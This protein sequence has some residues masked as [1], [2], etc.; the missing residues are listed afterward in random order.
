MSVPHRI[1]NET[2]GRQRLKAVCVITDGH[3]Y[4]LSIGTDPKGPRAYL[5]P[6][7]GGIEFGERASRAA[8]RE[9]KEEIG[10]DIPNPRLLGILENI[11][12]WNGQPGHEVV[13]C[14]LGEVPSRSLVPPH[15]P[16]SNGEDISLVWLSRE[17]LRSSEIPIYPDGLVDLLL[18]S[19]RH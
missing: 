5:L 17:E 3:D 10:I 11:F 14:F 7:G 4:L 6:V 19:S 12:T 1:W 8:V 2:P 18:E 9:I 13:F 15:G 16:E